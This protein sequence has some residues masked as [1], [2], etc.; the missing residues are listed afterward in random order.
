MKYYCEKC[1]TTSTID[2]FLIAQWIKEDADYD[3]EGDW[4]HRWDG[5][6]VLCDI[7]SDEVDEVW[8]KCVPDY[9]T[10]AQ[11]EKR[12]GK[13]LSDEAAVWFKP[14]NIYADFK[15]GICRYITAKRNDIK[16]IVIADPPVPPSDDFVPE[17]S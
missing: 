12:T 16:T 13:L 7:C 1:K 17:E 6:R 14:E 10:P 8:M 3:G 5:S 15:W 11:Y 2:D 4:N 9:E